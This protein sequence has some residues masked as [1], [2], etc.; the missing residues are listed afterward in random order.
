[1][2]VDP[3]IDRGHVIERLMGPLLVVLGKPGFGVFAD[4][5]E[6]FEQVHVE[7]LGSI[8]AIEAFD[9]G[10]LGRFARLDELEVDTVLLGPVGQADRDKFRPVV[11]AQLPWIAP[12]FRRCGR[13]HAPLA[14]LAG[15]GRFRWPVP[16]G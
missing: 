10:V 5:R 12:G 13:A 15:S 11:Q 8:G 3:V 1:M 2:V 4:L 7:H 9:Q 16:H 14:A 6:T